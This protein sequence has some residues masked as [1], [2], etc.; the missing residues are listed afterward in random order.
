M[1]F[2]EAKFSADAEID[3]TYDSLSD[4]STIGTA[5]LGGRIR[6]TAEGKT[7][8][9]DTGFFVA[10]KTEVLAK[11]NGSAAIDDAWGQLGT[12]TFAVKIGR[13][14]G[15]AL[16]E[17]G[18]D[19]YVAKAYTDPYKVNNARGRDNGGIAVNFNPSDSLMVELGAIYGQ[20][21]SALSYGDEA[22]AIDINKFGF[23]PLVKFTAGN[24]TVKG[25]ADM[26]FET[27]KDQDID[28]TYSEIGFG[29]E[30]N[31]KVSNITVNVGAGSS[32][33]KVEDYDILY[34]ASLEETITT[35]MGFVNIPVGENLLGFGAAMTNLDEADVNETYGFAVYELKLPV[36]NAWLKF[37]VSFASATDV[38]TD[39][40]TEDVTDVGGR[41]RLN[42]TF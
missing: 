18:E 29:G 8:N 24:I 30:I 14:E 42:Y 16:L 39:D 38:P 10:G 26:Y 34:G 21:S 23:R 12:K 31:A 6:L 37:A 25:G 17:P 35:I 40:G 20:G 22:V 15:E 4:G 28:G 2:A 27:P 32:K 9:K 11:I 13:F 19:V 5:D 3:T 41:V 1:A 7:E 33:N 36:E